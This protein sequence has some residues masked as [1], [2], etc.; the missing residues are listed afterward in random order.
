MVK[1]GKG[2]YVEEDEEEDEEM[3]ELEEEEVEDEDEMILPPVVLR[4]PIA[5]L[6][7]A[8]PTKSKIPQRTSSS[9]AFGSTTIPAFGSA[10]T[11]PAFGSTATTTGFGA[12]ITASGF[13]FTAPSVF[14]P[15]KLE[16]EKE[17]VK[18]PTRSHIRLPKAT[19]FAPTSSKSFSAGAPKIGMTV[20][21]STTTAL[22]LPTFTF[23]P[24][25]PSTIVPVAPQSIEAAD[26]TSA[27]ESAK[28]V[29]VARSP[30]FTFELPRATWKGKEVDQVEK[31]VMDL[32]REMSRKELPVVRL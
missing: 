1:K 7:I 31:G 28:L 24:P 27:K 26:E 12:P 32:V 30:K 14:E 29:D 5:K 4:R 17:E 9:S 15:P 25:P 8:S 19:A 18:I 6:P 20:T 22:T 11:T 21:P 23:A 10:T 13:S 2:K 16:E 3:D